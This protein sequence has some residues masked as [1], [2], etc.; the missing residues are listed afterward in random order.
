MYIYRHTY[1]F[2]SEQSWKLELN[3]LNGGLFSHSVLIWFGCGL[4]PPKFLLKFNCGYSSEA[5][6]M[7][8]EYK[9]SR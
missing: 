3:N 7:G 1:K 8:Q 6:G 2:S 9:V 5:L 4:L